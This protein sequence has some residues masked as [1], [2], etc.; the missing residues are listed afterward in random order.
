MTELPLLDET[1]ATDF[2]PLAAMIRQARE[3]EGLSMR[4]LARRSDL[5]AAQISRIETG[6]VKPSMETLAKLAVAL[7]RPLEPLLIMTLHREPAQQGLAD[8]RRLLHGLQRA[9]DDDL[10]GRLLELDDHEER[11][12]KLQNDCRFLEGT[13]SAELQ[14]LD[15][16]RAQLELATRESE[17]VAA[18]A[19]QAGEAS[20]SAQAEETTARA[21]SIFNA[22]SYAEAVA[23][24]AKA[25]VDDHRRKLHAER[26][27]LESLVFDTAERLFL[28]VSHERLTRIR[29]L[30]EP[31]SLTETE[32]A[33][34]ADAALSA[35]LSLRLTRTPDAG[36]PDTRELLD[37]WDALTDARRK[38]VLDFL[39]DQRRLSAQE[40]ATDLQEGGDLD[41]PDQDEPE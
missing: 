17:R 10:P 39:E 1:Y 24:N 11:V 26:S 21:D 32:K 15:H 7:E 19:Q 41:M 36:D 2:G 23:T 29:A 8:V 3:L 33:E 25:A 5:S 14:R 12:A 38:R 6:E 28:S 4:G 27:E 13:A 9:G 37:K 40:R 31:P 34:W 22:I 35:T 30:T 16:L 20:R 18:L